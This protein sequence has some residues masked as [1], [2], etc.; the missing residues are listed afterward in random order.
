MQRGAPDA[1][2]DFRLNFDVATTGPDKHA[3]G[4][5]S[6]LFKLRRDRELSDGVFTRNA[7]LGFCLFCFFFFKSVRNL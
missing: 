7:P 3:L 2:A 6:E 4:T 1:V 5:V